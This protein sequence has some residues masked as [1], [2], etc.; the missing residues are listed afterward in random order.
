MFRQWALDR[1]KKTKSFTIPGP[2]VFSVAIG[3][4]MNVCKKLALYV[5]KPLSATRLNFGRKSLLGVK[6][7]SQRSV[8][9]VDKRIQN[10]HKGY[11]WDGWIDHMPM[12]CQSMI[13]RPPVVI[14]HLY[15]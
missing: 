5:E 11:M 15:D 3:V 7:S 13:Y 12:S 2:L 4:Q 10:I 6:V 8:L 14:L 9:H 1:F